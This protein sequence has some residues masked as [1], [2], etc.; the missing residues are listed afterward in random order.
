[1][2]H[3]EILDGFAE[4]NVALAETRAAAREA[5]VAS[6]ET[7]NL[8]YE[9]RLLVEHGRI[10]RLRKLLK[11]NPNA[12]RE[13]HGLAVIAAD[14]SQV[15]VLELLIEYGADL[16]ERFPGG[17]RQ[18]AMEYACINGDM[19]TVKVLLDHGAKIT[20]RQTEL[21]S[22]KIN[23]S[24]PA[25]ARC[26]KYIVDLLE[27]TRRRRARL[28]LRSSILAI[29]RLYA[30]HARTIER[31]Y[32]PGGA[33]YNAAEASFAT[34]ALAA[35]SISEP[36]V[37]EA[38][39]P[40]PPVPQ[41]PPPPSPPPSPQGPSTPV[42]QRM[43]TIYINH[44]GGPLPLLGQQPSVASFLSKYPSNLPYRP[45]A[46]V[47]VTAHWETEVTTVSC[48]ETHPLLFD[49]GGF[50]PS[51][52]EYK[53]P[54]SGSPQL[55]E[56]ICTLLNTAGLPHARDATR[57]WDHGVFVPM[58]LLYPDASMPIVQLSLLRSQQADTH[59]A[60]GAALQP[61][62]DE[63]VLIIGSGVAFHNFDYLF[64][65]PG[66]KKHSD[67][68]MHNRAFD[69]WLT[70]TMT[71]MSI[72]ASERIERLSQW[73]TTAP[74]ARE[75]HPRGA[76][77]HL[78]P[79][80]VVA[81]AAG[82]APGRKV[83]PQEAPEG[84][85]LAG[86]VMS[87]FEFV[88]QSPPPPPSAPPSPPGPSAG[89]R[90]SFMD[91][92]L[93][94]PAVSTPS[95]PSA[96]SQLLK[97][98]LPSFAFKCSGWVGKVVA[99][100]MLGELPPEEKAY[101]IAAYGLADIACN[102]LGRSAFFCATDALQT[103]AANAFG[104]KRFTDVGDIM[105]RS[106]LVAFLF[107][108][109]PAVVLWC[110]AEP[111]L[112]AL[113]QDAAVVS[114]AAVYGRIRTRWLIFAL[115][116][117]V[118]L[119]TLN[120]TGRALPGMLANGVSAAL[121]VPLGW[122]FVVRL[123]LGLAGAAYL[124]TA[125]EASAFLT[126][127]LGVLCSSESRK[128]FIRPS[129]RALRGWGVYLSIAAPAFFMLGLEMAAWE[130]IEFP[131][132]LCKP[133]PQ[134]A[135]GAFAILYNLCYV[136]EAPGFGLCGG[137]GA[138]VGNALGA[139]KPD[140]ARQAAHIAL[141]TAVTVAALTSSGLYGLARSGYVF[142]LY[143]ADEASTAL[144]VSL[145]PE[146]CIGVFCSNIAWAVAGVL[147]GA[148]RQHAV[149]P[150]TFVA[151]FVIGLPLGA[152]SAFV[153][154]ADGFRG[155]FRGLI[156]GLGLNAALGLLLVFGRVIRLPCAIDW[157]A[158][159]IVAQRRMDEDARRRGLGNLVVEPLPP[160]NGLL[161]NSG[162][163]N[164]GPPPA[165]ARSGTSAVLSLVD[166]GL[167]SL[168]D[169]E[170]L[171]ALRHDASTSPAALTA[172]L[173]ACCADL[174]R[175]RRALLAVVLLAEVEA[176]RSAPAALRP[177][178]QH[179]VLR[180]AKSG[181]C[182][183]LR[184]VLS[185]SLVAAESDSLLTV[186]WRPS[187]EC[188]GGFLEHFE[189]PT[190][191]VRFV[192]EWSGDESDANIIE[193]N[194]YHESVR[195]FPAREALSWALLKPRPAVLDAVS[196]NVA[197]CRSSVSSGAGEGNGGAFIAIHVRRTDHYAIAMRRHV[198]DGEFFRYCDHHSIPSSSPPP[199]FLATDCA[200][201]QRA[202]RQRY[203]RRCVVG[204]HAIGQAAAFGGLRQTALLAS[205]V[206]LL[207]C[208]R[209][210]RFKGSRYS[211]FSDAINRLRQVGG[212]ASAHDEHEHLD[213]PH[214]TPAWR[215]SILQVAQ[216]QRANGDLTVVRLLA[217]TPGLAEAIE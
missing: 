207:T 66:T 62:R 196:A 4:L 96:F 14:Y 155:L 136:L 191:R 25:W 49:Y 160:S 130:T 197:A 45:K 135:L 101:A 80:L 126:Y 47:I 185:Y 202:F 69:G 113:G 161:I 31:L 84:E 73:Q 17:E 114:R 74:S 216:E 3:T 141:L 79:A 81:G 44:G 189:P 200:E 8:E 127:M 170:L 210:E 100:R 103:M 109:L 63:G 121:A 102:L 176:Q 138:L 20:Q 179:I 105:W 87:Q 83:G 156:L 55:A 171:D 78:L 22:A 134:A 147:G 215:R 32:V 217:N 106:L 143:H 208:G 75:A 97:L 50:P 48:G 214:D 57:G 158:E 203:G 146:L 122:L 144:A 151:Y 182:N 65:R 42:E 88:S 39:D 137:A 173:D 120:A 139:G 154:P 123:N 187:D 125:I 93:L 70:E 150:C 213:P 117:A 198:S 58:M 111:I 128:W 184:T 53:Y 12:A 91:D 1:M 118:L 165:D 60:V 90:A 16:D 94:P 28:R 132:G 35:A 205:V 11:E 194:D 82:G 33:G 54:A 9:F 104:A 7:S 29:A 206:D 145:L 152:V 34:A 5:E 159:A 177:S 209:A 149:W 41:S 204:G 153:W 166:K 178:R 115:C 157:P 68:V 86:F 211:S 38:S 36:L 112:G 183:R 162:S 89:R 110:F 186:V 37:V 168:V 92:L 15:G 95:P 119:K 85:L 67:G 98:W 40:A 163:V 13:F 181:L 195:H 172:G 23:S 190:P 6:A 61:L 131:A 124:A 46:V 129:T 148:G 56:R 193:A 140:D 188:P 2:S 167:L 199:I 99:I 108:Y 133:S 169:A 26:S 19:S 21:A 71:S 30:W 18:T 10:A 51:T 64:A 52:Y 24:N 107:L 72:S 201:T 212:A 59:L 175:E 142:E 116:N 192:T 43:P 27:V 77:E 180:C 174:A 76:A 164:G